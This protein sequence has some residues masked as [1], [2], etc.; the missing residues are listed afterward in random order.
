MATKKKGATKGPKKSKTAKGAKGF[1]K[2]S[3]RRKVRGKLG[4]TSK[5]KSAAK[6]AVPAPQAPSKIMAAMGGGMGYGS[7]DTRGIGV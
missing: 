6:K 2:D 4:T 5:K 7:A 3:L 1:G